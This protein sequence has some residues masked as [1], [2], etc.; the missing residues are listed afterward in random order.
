M[1]NGVG[2]KGKLVSLL[3]LGNKKVQRE[4]CPVVGSSSSSAPPPRLLPVCPILGG[5]RPLGWELPAAGIGLRAHVLHPA[6][7]SSLSGH[8]LCLLFPPHTWSRQTKSALALGM[9]LQ[10]NAHRLP[11]RLGPP[12]K[13]PLWEFGSGACLLGVADRLQSSVWQ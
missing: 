13:S 10:G 7:C 2:R 8:C 5:L 9:Q 3:A 11:A 4:S 1:A 12:S 6:E